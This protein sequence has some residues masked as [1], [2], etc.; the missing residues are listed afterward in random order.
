[1]KSRS[2]S[3]NRTAAWPL[4]F[5]K[6]NDRQYIELVPETQAGSDRLGH[7]SVETT[8][9]DAMRRYLGARHQ[10]PRH[11]SYR[12]D[13]QRQLQRQRTPTAHA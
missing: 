9:A 4:A 10:G 6:I 7:I 11:Y 1:M 13:R 5:I 2:N 3:T 12:P 8:D